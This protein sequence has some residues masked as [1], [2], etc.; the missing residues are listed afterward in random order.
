MPI[1]KAPPANKYRKHRPDDRRG[2]AA[3]D[4]ADEEYS[5][6]A[7]AAAGCALGDCH[8]GGRRHVQSILKEQGLGGNFGMKE[9]SL[10]P[11]GK[12]MYA[13]AEVLKADCC[14]D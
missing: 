9:S 12:F 6:Q 2:Y 14:N 3:Q 10:R 4:E 7:G 11:A 13:L 8:R 1:V 5:Q